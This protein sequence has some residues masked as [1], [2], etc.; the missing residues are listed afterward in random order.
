MQTFIR[1]HVR[2]AKRI[3]PKQT[4]LYLL[5]PRV[6]PGTERWKN[7]RAATLDPACT[8]RVPYVSMPRQRAPRFVAQQ[9]AH[10]L[11]PKLPPPEQTLVHVH[12]LYPG[13][14][15]VPALKAA[16]YRVVLMVHGSDWY[17]VVDK[18]WFEPMIGPVLRAADQVCVSGDDLK[19]AILKQYPG[20]HIH[21]MYNYIDTGLFRPAGEE[22]QIVAEEAQEQKKVAREEVQEAQKEVQEAQN[23]AQRALGWDSG[24]KHVLTVANIRH[25]KGV[26]RLLKAAI[27]L[28]RE[29][30]DGSGRGEYGERGDASANKG[31]VF[32][33][34]G[35]PAQ[36]AYR[37][38]IRE[39]ARELEQE[40][41]GDR[42]EGGD[43]R[44]QGEQ[45][46]KHSRIEAILHPPVPREQLAMYY[47]AA[48]LYVIPSRSEGFN[49]S[50]LEAA[51]T[52]L[53]VLATH[54]GGAGIVLRD[55]EGLLI[56]NG[57]GTEAGEKRVIEMLQ[58]GLR[59]WLRDNVKRSAASSAF[60]QRHYS[61][62]TYE[63]RLREL[64]GMQK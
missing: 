10:H 56:E 42:G 24:R 35:Q 57:D 4:Q 51:A 38:E 3:N 21:V 33:L 8:T 54:T 20:L 41:E 60:I 45:S 52:G 31:V 48:D 44:A 50:L 28:Q 13:G 47:R 55:C 64:Y 16:G 26:D 40:S 12:W 53:P 17:K 1:D 32:H 9:I 11:I 27:G 36:G 22:A 63:R 5:T 23:E 49:V 7:Q 30:R 46:D 15:A 43:R 19:E 59:H 37:Q 58:Q 14:M 29:C 18:P 34:I 62:E 61:F 2:V 25:E 39:L 6:V